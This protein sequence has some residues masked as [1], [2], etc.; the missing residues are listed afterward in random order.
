MPILPSSDA[1]AAERAWVEIDT[2]AIAHNIC[3]LQSVLTPGTDLLAVVKADAYGHG[4]VRVAALAEQLEVKSFGVATVPEGIELRQAGIR[5]SILVMGA[6][7]SRA[8]IEAIAQWRLE[9]TLCDPV[10]AQCFAD[11]LSAP[12]P[13]HLKIDTGMS[14]LGYPWEQCADFMQQVMALPHLHVASLYSHLA[15]ADDP[16]PR[17][18]KEQQAR[19]EEAI[20]RSRAAGIPIPTLHLAN[21]AGTLFSPAMHYDR[22][23]VGLS[24]YGIYPGPQ[25]EAAIA[26]KPAM[27]VRARIAHIRDLP[28]GVGISYGHRFVTANPCR[29]AVISIGYADGV[30]R[31]LSNRMQV[32]VRGQRVPQL[33]I[34]TMDQ[35]V[36]DVTAIPD[37]AVGD[38]V[39]LLGKDGSSNIPS[40]EWSR[41]LD[42]IPYEIACGFQQ[43][44]PRVGV[45]S[46]M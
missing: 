7:Q 31:N 5:A 13:V 16:D 45:R 44:L 4:A 27:Q 22:V 14:R 15:T 33:G 6:V 19:F 32:L 8:Q 35:I 30:P 43:R 20:G 12:L 23:R 21:S 42:T 18:M 36:I 41:L 11:A 26:L 3:A 1:L 17:F 29:V 25:F 34:I 46:S 2:E 28:A 24:L 10:Q 37:A 40:E 39:T 38:S 9:P